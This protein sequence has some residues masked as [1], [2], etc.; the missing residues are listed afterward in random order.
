M[1]KNSPLNTACNVTFY[2]LPPRV[3]MLLEEDDY[4]GAFEKLTRIVEKGSQGTA[5][6]RILNQDFW[7]MHV[8]KFL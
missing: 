1:P 6:L 4:D 8:T 7:K 5:T 2:R 3:E